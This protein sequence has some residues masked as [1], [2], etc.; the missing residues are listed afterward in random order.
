MGNGSSVPVDG[1]EGYHVLRVQDQSPGQVAGLEPFFD[2]IVS[3]G[4][5]RLVCNCFDSVNNT[6]CLGQRR[7]KLQGDFE[8]VHWSATRVDS[9]QQQ[10]SDCA[11]NPNHSFEQLGRPRHLRRFNSLLLVWRCQSECVAYHCS[12]S[13]LASISSRPDWRFRLCSWCWKCSSTSRRP[14]LTRPSQCWKARQAVRL[15]RWVWQCSWSHVG[16]KRPMGRRR[17]SWMWH[18]IRIFAPYSSFGR[19]LSTNTGTECSSPSVW[20][21]E[22]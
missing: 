5:K 18:W 8:A 6:P 20:R 11:T 4:N 3:I 15:Q 7:R 17:M 16:S 1:T 12:S 21:N 9:L 14:N 13:Q 22:D 2:F 10:V 19:P